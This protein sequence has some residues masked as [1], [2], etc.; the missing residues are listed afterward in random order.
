MSRDKIFKKMK[1][2]FFTLLIVVSFNFSLH[3]QTNYSKVIDKS[4]T[5]T[6]YKQL[7]NSINEDATT[8]IFDNGYKYLSFYK[9]G[10]EI[11]IINGKVHTIFLHNQKDP[12]FNS[13]TGQLPGNLSWGMSKSDVHQKL[14]APTKNGG[15]GYF[16]GEQTLYWDKYSY[17]SYALH[18]TYKENS[19][20]EVSIMSLKK[21]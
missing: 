6:E 8:K 13:Y 1:H 12:K 20:F 21:P 9:T 18:F 11:L 10:I 16:L 5:S 2:F 15:G 7:L 19:V 4:T 17:S 14:G 3:S